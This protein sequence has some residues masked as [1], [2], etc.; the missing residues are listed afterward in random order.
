M[1]KKGRSIRGIKPRQTRS[2]VI[3][4]LATTTKGGRGRI[5]KRSSYKKN[6]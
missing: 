6:M 3:K 4:S 5:K 1:V 2:R